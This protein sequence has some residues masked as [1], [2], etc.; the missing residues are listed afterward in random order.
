MKMPKIFKF[1]NQAQEQPTSNLT[2][3]EPWTEYLAG[4]GHI[5]SEK[6]AIQISAVFRCV[7]IITKTMAAMPL[8]LYKRTDSGKEKATEHRLYNMLY[9]LPNP[10]T[11]AYEFWQMYVANL[12]LT[13][14]GFAKI[15]RD[16]NGY[17]QEIWNIP[18]CNVSGVHINSKTGERYIDV[19]DSDANGKEVYGERLREGEFMHTPGFLMGSRTEANSLIS[20]AD[21]VLGMTKT[22]GEYAKN[23]VDGVNPGGFIE[24]PSH[25]SNDAYERFKKDFENN[26]RG[27]VNNGR[28]L[29][30]EEGAKANLFQRDMEK[31]QVLESRKWAVT[32][33]CRI[34]G[35]PP[36]LCMDMEHATFSNIE[37]QSMEFIRDCINPMSVRLE[38]TMYRDLLSRRER[39]V[40]YWKFNTNSL[41][42]GDTAARTQYYSAMRQ[43]G[44]FSV[45]D[46]MDLEDM[47]RVP[48]E[49]GGDDHHL[50]G[51]MILLE[52]ARLNIPKGA[53]SAKGMTA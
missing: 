6:E 28:F 34:F 50:N 47:N 12:L 31:N 42:R 44:N 38:Q 23:A 30:L 10:Q 9:A 22:L 49:L 5:L 25:L 26:Y 51:N 18:T 43:N 46:V 35:V 20:I 1:R 15:V 39:M 14:G 17:I 37:Q 36:H 48:A 21:E 2:A 3:W 16:R 19:Y 13:R 45:N 29:F 24:H 40:Y 4:K 53:Q 11:T 8:H 7:D 41:M 32:E 52:N 33:V 27:A